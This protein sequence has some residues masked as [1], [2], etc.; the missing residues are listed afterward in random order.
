AA[1]L[2]RYRD[3]LTRMVALRIVARV[4]RIVDPCDVVHETFVSAAQQLPHY[5]KTLPI[6]F[7][8][9]L[10]RLA[11]QTLA[12]VHERHLDAGCRSV[13]RERTWG[14]PTTES[15]AIEIVRLLDTNNST[16]SGELARKELRRSVRDALY[17]LPVVD[18]EVLLQRYVK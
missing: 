3:R 13:R 10:R 15:P 18:R 6:P 5:L 14:G 17:Q 1:L 16:P 2:L 9:W 12:H 7:Y 8:P 11:W 4:R